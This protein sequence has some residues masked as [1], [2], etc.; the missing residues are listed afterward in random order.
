M[1][2]TGVET[3]WT[4]IPF[5][6]GDKPRVMG[7]LNWQTMNTVWLR[8]RTDAGVDGWG[9]AFGHA[10]AAGTL[11]VLDTQLAPA[12]IGQDAR[13]IAGVRQKLA[14]AFHT[15]GRNGPHVFALS[16]L[17]IALWDI[18]GKTANQPLW[19]CSAARPW[20]R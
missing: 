9:E 10:A 5:D 6:M 8:V 18:A 17:D 13:D 14:K 7:G 15:F 11:T 12:V 4:Q 20:N 2:I 3:Y 16:A 1:K 19:A